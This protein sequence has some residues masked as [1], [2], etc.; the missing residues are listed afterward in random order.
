MA[1]DAFQIAKREPQGVPV[2]GVGIG[3]HPHAVPF[4]DALHAVFQVSEPVECAADF[5]GRNA[6]HQSHQRGG[7]GIAVAHFI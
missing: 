3:E 7:H 6:P 4:P 2:V 1:G 5:L